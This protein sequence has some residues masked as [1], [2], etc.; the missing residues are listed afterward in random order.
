MASSLPKKPHD[1]ETVDEVLCLLDEDNTG[2]VEFKEFLVLVFKVARACFKTLNESPKD[3]CL[4]D[5]SV[6]SKELEQGQR[7]GAEVAK[8]GAAQP[9]E[10]SS[11]EQRDQAPRGQDKV[12][13][14]TQNQ[15]SYSTQVSSLDRQAESQTQEMISQETQV[16]GQ[17]EQ[18]PRIEDKNWTRQKRS[19]RQP[20]ISQQ[21]DEITTGSTS[22]TQTQ[23][24]TFYT[25]G[26]TCD[27]NR[28]TNSHSQDR[29]QA[30]PV[31]IQHYQTQAGSHTQ[32]HTQM[33]EQGWEQQTG[34]GSIQTQG[35][36][37]D[38][39]RG[40]EI[41]GQDRNQASQTP[42]EHYQAQAESYTQTHSQTIDQGRSQQS[43]N[44]RVQTYRSSYGQNRG[45]EFHGQKSNQAE[46][47]ET[48]HYQTQAGS[49]TQTLEH[50]GS[51]SARQVVA[52][53]KGQ[54]Q[55]QSCMGQ[56]WTPV[57]NYETGEPVLEGQVQTKTDTVKETQQWNSNHKSLTGG[58][59][60]REYPQWLERSGSMTT[61]GK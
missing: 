19:E 56:N 7:S 57:S 39:G 26:S 43:E 30:D 54:T 5:K 11:Y 25:Q 27:Q 12:R 48:G 10:D 21:T 13:T 4:S 3:A 9:C 40:T 32:I 42:K 29:S 18:T 55:T 59:G 61:Q 17:V 22:Q 46:Q 8:D 37:Y 44:S 33:V 47:V 41:R 20:Q 58:Q 28:G 16:T 35:P 23:A 14:H 24:G 51:Q 50:D 2:T 52:Q 34:S 60:E 38:Q 1:P 15:H 45:T 6:S 53:V 31:S 49:Y 36:I